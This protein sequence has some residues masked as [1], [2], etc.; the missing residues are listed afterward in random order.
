MT[1]SVTSGKKGVNFDIVDKSTGDTLVENVSDWSDALP[2]TGDYTIRVY[3]TKGGDTYTLKVSVGDR[4]G[5]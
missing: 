3:S 4:E 1:V 5:E 2:S